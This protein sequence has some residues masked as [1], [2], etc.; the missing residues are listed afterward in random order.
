MSGMKILNYRFYL[1]YEVP[2]GFIGVSMN[3]VKKRLKLFLLLFLLVATVGTF[4]FMRLEHLSIIDALYF[5]IVT[6]AT[7][8]YGDIYPHAALSRMFTILLIIA[9][10]AVFLGVIAN[11][12]ELVILKRDF[13]GRMKKVNMVLGVFFSEVGNHLL[14]LF[15]NHNKGIN[16]VRESLLITSGWTRE[17]FFAARKKMAA[18]ELKADSSQMDL[19]NL[20]A[21]LGGKRDFLVGLLENPVLVEHEGFSEALLAVFH[22]LDELNSRKDLTDIPP[23]DRQHL[24]GDMN[25]AYGQLVDQWL[26]YLAHLKDQYPYIFSLAV[27]KNPFNPNA[28]TV[29]MS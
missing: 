6:M 19:V 14:S 12:T 18:T 13:Q 11:A 1:R 24:T 23:T 27:R 5:N 10:G 25:R 26:V 17:Q 28:D 29:V 7:V 21:F 8:G 16:A 20:N 4:G 2:P 9:G 15:S 3:E 22:L